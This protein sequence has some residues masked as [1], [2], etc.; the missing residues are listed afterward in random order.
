[1]KVCSICGKP[2]ENENAP[3]LT[4]SGF[5]NARYLCDECSDEM[6]VA[7]TSRDVEE[8]EA[9]VSVLGEKMEKCHDEQAT[10]TLFSFINVACERLSKIKEG[11]YDFAI[12]ERM[13]EIADEE[14][15]D[16]I[17]EE[18]QE[19]EED[20]ALDAEDAKKQE[21]FDKIMNWLTIGA[22]AITAIVLII[23]FIG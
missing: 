15:M 18:L 13:K 7:M 17:P 12:D 6:D 1:M 4:I 5:G 21:K 23:R 9:A 10:A 19:T 2:I 8:I 14:G 11:T 20:K 22:I 3:I 16:E